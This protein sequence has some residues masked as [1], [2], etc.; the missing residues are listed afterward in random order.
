MRL[1]SVG[2]AAEAR[3]TRSPD[4]SLVGKKEE[5][6]KKQL[7]FSDAEK[8]NKATEPFDEQALFERPLGA[9]AERKRDSERLTI[10]SENGET[11][12]LENTQ[13]SE[14]PGKR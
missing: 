3:E 4:A 14:R 12:G 1:K 7:T 10:G 9:R 8:R 5:R 11:L 13:K 2:T 6:G